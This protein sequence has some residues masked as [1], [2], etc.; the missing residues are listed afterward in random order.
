MSSE[1][2]GVDLAFRALVAVRE[3]AEKDNAPGAVVRRGGRELRWA[4]AVIS[5]MVAECGMAV[6][7]ASGIR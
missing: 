6:L 1:Q 7:A 4:G 3:A 5:T 2:G